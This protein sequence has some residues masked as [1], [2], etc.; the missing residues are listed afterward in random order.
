MQEQEWNLNAL[1]ENKESV[2]ECLKALQLTT[3]DFETTYQ[4]RLKTLSATQFLE[5][6][7]HYENL[8]EKISSV[9]TY[10]YLLFAKN[11]KEAKFYSQC[12]MA[13]ADIQQHILFF[14]IEFV[15]L[16]TKKQLAFIKKCK[17]HAFYLNNLIEK[18]KHTLKLDEERIALALSPV[19][20]GAF[21]RLFDEHLSSLKIPFKEQTLSEEEILAL[22]HNPNRKTRKKAQ[23]AFSAT[24]E[25]SRFLLT[26]ILN[27][28]RKNLL[29]ETK[30][31]NY[32]KKESFRHIDNQISQDSVNSMI[33]IVNANFSLVHRY[34]HKK[35]QI[36]GHKLKDYDRY[37][38]LSTE[39]A[40]M[41]YSQAVEETLN[42]FKAFSPEFHKIA[43]KAI[44]DGWVDSHPREFKQGGAFSHGAVPSAHPYVLLNYTGNRRDAFTIAHEFGHMI[45]QE[46]SKK[47]GVLNMDTPLTTA[48]TAS[49]FAEMLLFEHLKK[50]LKQDELLF[51]LA[52][53]LEDIFS[54]LFRQVVMTNFERRI[55]EIDAEL[56][57]KDFDKIWFEE[58][59]R[60]FERSVK[61]TKNYHLWW[62]YIPHFIHSPFYCYAYSYGQLLTL[63]LYGLY[64]KSDT[65]TFV[66]TYTEF[67]SLGGSKSPKEL[68]AMFGFDIDSKEFWEI[69]MQEVSHLLE[70]F[71]RLVACKES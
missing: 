66:K 37:A 18:K 40:T 27:M 34:Y 14:E 24:L 11:T 50:S 9:M 26:Y 36:L 20:A 47:Q 58:N 49:V 7:K 41:A 25:K 42:A 1:F 21:S 3:K 57:T 19:G 44:K 39:N 30:L 68:V 65:K 53:K 46:L 51:M 5:A 31:R 17:N 35:A 62:S 56:D 70:E 60:M 54:T 6:L 2:E 71:E 69:G 16:D 64:K 4:N 13:C 45:H 63:A 10:A 55:H 67:L 59:Q 8:L 15:N 23:K 22:L 12:E 48:E 38:P 33:D 32:E 43:S 52:G 61:L 28:V 29:I